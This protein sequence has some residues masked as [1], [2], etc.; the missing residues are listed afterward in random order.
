MNTTN[1]ERF[2]WLQLVYTIPRLLGEVLNKDLR[3]S[4]SSVIFDHNLCVCIL[5]HREGF[6]R[7]QDSVPSSRSLIS[8]S[9]YVIFHLRSGNSSLP[10]NWRENDVIKFGHA[11]R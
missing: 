2:R 8:I 10:N 9:K 11:E 5:S 7:F 1:K 6:F 4:V 3:L